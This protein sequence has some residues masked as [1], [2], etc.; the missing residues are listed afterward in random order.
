MPGTPA[1]IRPLADSPVGRTEERPDA[2][3]GENPG[4]FEITYDLR[5]GEGTDGQKIDLGYGLGLTTLNDMVGHNGA[6]IGYTSFIFAFPEHDMTI[7][8]LG[9][10]SN[11]FTTD[12]TT[13]GFSL[14]KALYP[15][16]LA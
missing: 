14:I 11:N 4:N 1:E 10:E 9:N 15:D 3:T 2:L 12:A 7:V 13:I 5:L 6:I 8:V 16:Q